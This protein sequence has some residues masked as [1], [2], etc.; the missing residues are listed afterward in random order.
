MANLLNK[1]PFTYEEERRSFLHDLQ[2]FHQNR[3]Y[4]F[5]SLESRAIVIVF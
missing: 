3:G 2:G 1:D 4:V 5:D